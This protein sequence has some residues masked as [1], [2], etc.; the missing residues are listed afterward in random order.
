MQFGIRRSYVRRHPGTSRSGANRLMRSRIAAK[1]FFGSATSASRSALTCATRI[2]RI[3][4][5]QH[6]QRSRFQRSRCQRRLLPAS[7][8]ACVVCCLRRLLPASVNVRGSALPSVKDAGNLS[9][10]GPVQ[11]PRGGNM[12]LVRGGSYESGPETGG[13]TTDRSYRDTLN[14]AGNSEE[15]GFR[16][17]RSLH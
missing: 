13:R 9:P 14:M 8:V 10:A 4:H 17:V 11:L 16:T 15:M 6:R 12:R 3:A 5:C 7:P 1:S 2:A